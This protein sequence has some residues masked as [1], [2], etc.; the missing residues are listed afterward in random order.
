M[1]YEVVVEW[2]F[3]LDNF[4]LKWIDIYVYGLIGFGM[5]VKLIGC[6]DFDVDFICKVLCFIVDWLLVELKCIVGDCLK[7][8]VCYVVMFE[9]KKCCWCLNYVCEYYFD[10][11]LMINNV[12]CVNGGELV[13]D[14]KLWEFKLMNLKGYKVFFECRVVLI[15]ILWM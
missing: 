10:I 13:F 5:M 2:F 9:E 1:S 11:L 3:G 6:E 12:K 15:F 8:N 14:K 4:F 7:E